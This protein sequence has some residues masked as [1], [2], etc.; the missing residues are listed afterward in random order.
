M[1][2]GTFLRGTFGR[3]SG[4]GGVSRTIACRAKRVVRDL[5]AGA[6]IPPPVEDAQRAP[7]APVHRIDADAW[8]GLRKA[9]A[10]FAEKEAG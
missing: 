1:V 3:A 10:A 6:P 2:S 8:H 5:L 7:A 4:S 9:E